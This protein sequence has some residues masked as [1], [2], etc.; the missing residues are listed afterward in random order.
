MSARHFDR[1]NK[2]GRIKMNPVNPVPPVRKKHGRHQT[3]L[4]CRVVSCNAGEDGR[5]AIL[6]TSRAES[7]HEIDNKA[8]QQNQAKPA[9]A[10]DGT[11]KVKP[12]AAEQEKQ[13]NHE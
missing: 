6:W 11:A 1:I 5:R 8:Y 4:P 12:A 10:D 7:A 13:N 3:P 9:A 2:T